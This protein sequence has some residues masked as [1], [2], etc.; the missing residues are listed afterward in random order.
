MRHEKDMIDM[1]NQKKQIQ[2]QVEATKKLNLGLD[3]DSSSN[4]NRR[5]SISRFSGFINPKEISRL[6]EK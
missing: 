2:E 5:E 3:A 6:D 1:F 4:R